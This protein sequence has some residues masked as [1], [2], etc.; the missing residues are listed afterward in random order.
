MAVITENKKAL[1]IPDIHMKPWILDRAEV[2]MRKGA[3]DLAVSLGD[4]PDDFHQQRN[5][6]LYHETFRRI[7]KFDNDFPDT[8]WCIGNHDFSYLY[9]YDE[10]GFS[11]YAKDIVKRYLIDMMKKMGERMAYM[12]RIGNA[13]FSHGGLSREFADE[14][15]SNEELS[16]MDKAIERINRMKPQAMWDGISPIW[17]RPTYSKCKMFMA[18]KYLQVTG[19]TPV[20]APVEGDGFIILDTFSTNRDGSQYG[21]GKLVIVDTE[22]MKWMYGEG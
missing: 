11:V 2:V 3:A 15:L 17:L 4:Y 1:I 14:Y 16:D 20:R 7:E 22:S 13:V 9:D 6:E 18:D 5:T 8:L 21:E 12:H 10:S 19:H